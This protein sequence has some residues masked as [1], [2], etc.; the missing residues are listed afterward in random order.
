MLSFLYLCIF[1]VTIFLSSTYVC[2]H[3]YIC[4][5]HI[6]AFISC[7]YFSIIYLSMFVSLYLSHVHLYI[8]SDYFSIIYLSMLVSQFIA[9]A[10]VFFYGGIFTS[11]T[12]L[13]SHFYLCHM[14]ICTYIS[15]DHFSI[16][17]LSM[18]L[19]LSHVH[20]CLLIRPFSI[21]MIIY[22]FVWELGTLH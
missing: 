18:L 5:M 7:D 11:S 9:G 20:L 19:S 3:F 6:Y 10:F 22:S 2:S 4:H 21:C 1:H 17:Y 8:S 13:C 15:C 14:Y 12:D 16:I